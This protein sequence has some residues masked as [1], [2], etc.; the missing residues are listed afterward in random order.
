ML[1][2][3]LTEAQL[4]DHV[5]H[6]LIDHEVLLADEVRN[7]AFYEALR[8]RITPDS[9]VLDIGAGPGVWAIVAARLGAKRVVAID[10]N[11]LWMGVIK[12]LARECGVGDRVQPVFGYSTQI[13][14]E[15]EF[16][17]VVSETIGVDGFDEEIV[18]VMADARAR[19]L[20]KGGELI[21]ETLS[22]W[23]AG[24]HY[25]GFGDALPDG[26]PFDFTH[27]TALKRHA[28]VRLM[29]KSDLR[30]LT[31]PQKL[32]EANFYQAA[33]PFD[34]HNLLADWEIADGQGINCFS[35]WVESRLT[36]GVNMTTRRTSN[37][38]PIIYR[39]APPPAGPAK[40]E[41][42]LTFAEA[43]AYWT[44]NYS[45]AEW[46]ASHSY[47]PSIATKQILQDLQVSETPISPTGQS[48]IAELTKDSPTSII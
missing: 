33:P 15:K 25:K 16:D 4:Y 46:Q 21:P 19:F 18:E 41:F 43:A 35:V 38:M 26:V 7:R 22:L 23:V 34:L 29:R 17:L 14:L 6:L 24:G 32:I 48:L 37:W 42:S 1:P 27:F 28:P 9:V 47:S 10:S 20:K 2:A 3:N 40:I 12:Q 5:K 8:R 36:R 39:V 44:V 13:Q 31:K 45:G 11:E 30:L